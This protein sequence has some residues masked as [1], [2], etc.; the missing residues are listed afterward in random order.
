MC[1]YLQGNTGSDNIQAFDATG[2]GIPA[3]Y[4]FQRTRYSYGRTAYTPDFAAALKVGADQITVE[5]DGVNAAA[6]DR[7]RAVAVIAGSH[8]AR[9]DLL[10][11]CCV[12]RY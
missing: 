11:V 5:T 12:K 10:A 6:V 2:A 3:T 1:V 8:R 7:W 4:G 9:P